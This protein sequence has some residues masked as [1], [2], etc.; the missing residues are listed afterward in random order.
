M[1]YKDLLKDIDGLEGPYLL[2]GQ[3]EYLIDNT[4]SLIDDKIVGGPMRDLNYMFLDG[5]SVELESIINACET[6]PFMGEKKLVVLNNIA[7][8]IDIKENEKGLVEYL[9]QVQDHV[10]FLM[11]DNKNNL[12][13]TTSLYKK[14]KKLARDVEF[15]RLDPRKFS[16][17]V[18]RYLKSKKK[19]IGSG[20]LAY[21]V[22]KLGYCHYGSEKELYQMTNELDKLIHRSAEAISRNDINDSLSKSTEEN[23][24]G[25]L[26]ALLSK[27][28]DKSIGIFHELIGAK[29]PVQKIL[30]MIT[31]QYRLLA[32]IKSYKEV[33]Y[34][35]KQIKDKTGIKPFEYK[36]IASKSGLYSIKAINEGLK[37]ILSTDVK[38]KT[39]SQD[40]VLLM[41]MLIVNLVNLSN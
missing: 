12:K 32:S 7:S 29:E 41:E 5:K 33:G 36:K 17:W 4:V 16:A 26:E 20:D 13:K 40:E 31:R 1:D 38:Q 8:F 15:N 23:I 18:N 22:D 2:K 35:E 10:V 11:V 39:T 19:S 24:F 9:D 27:D 3:E 25:F 34:G 37:L 30:F 6:L 28:G 21:L 14:L